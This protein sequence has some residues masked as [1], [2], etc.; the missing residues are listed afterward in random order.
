MIVRNLFKIK[1]AF[2]I[3]SLRMSSI[4]TEEPL[5]AAAE[6]S[7]QVDELADVVELGGP[8]AKKLKGEDEV[9]TVVE[10]EV[11]E[12]GERLKKKKVALLLSYSGKGYY[13]MQLNPGFPTIEDELLTALCKAG[14]IPL[15]HKE[16]PSKMQFQRAA[17]TDKGVS[18]AMQVVSLKLW[19][20]VENA[21]KKVNELLPAQIRMIDF[22]RTTQ[23]FNCK[24]SCSHRTYSY[25]LPT[26]AFTPVEEMVLQSF[27]LEDPEKTIAKVN[28]VLALYKGTHNF[29]NFTSG[30]KPDEASS[31]RY[32]IDMQCSQ[33]FI[34]DGLE[35][36]VVTVKGQSFMLHQIRK[37]IGLMI[38][39]VRGL[40]SMDVISK[41]WGP[42]KVDIPKA[43]GLG[44]M[45]EQVHYDSY[46]KKYGYDGMHEPLIWDEHKEQIE[47]FKKK[48]IYSSMIE[49]EKAEKDMMKWMSTLFSHHFDYRIN[50][51]LP[52][53]AETAVG[54]AA[55][56]VKLDD[57]KKAAALVELNSVAGEDNTDTVASE[58]TNASNVEVP[59]IPAETAQQSET[60][61]DSSN[62]EALSEVDT[63]NKSESNG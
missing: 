56:L 28:E 35:W 8:P 10:K 3:R 45:L 36:A 29:H 5:N 14:V 40:A 4:P 17:R 63:S 52:A 50:V 38:A 20:N 31:M 2:C 21:I 7:Q 61:K 18:A 41:A 24:N 54:R 42:A 32:I 15:N 19:V 39:I 23:S 60:N 53:E 26:Y 58:N 22:K 34:Q 9:L 59:V 16:N 55:H 13:G 27:R 49:T 44:L 37:M 33:P 43:P 11:N 25:F 47:A 30:K 46:N 1:R 57:R 48:H 51:D 6:K 62:S 12:A